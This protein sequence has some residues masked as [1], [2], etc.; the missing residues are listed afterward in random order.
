[1]H[2]GYSKNVCKN[3]VKTT[4]ACS[5]FT[6]LLHTFMRQTAE[7]ERPWIEKKNTM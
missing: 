1:M 2:L 6:L 7:P 3:E 4:K 5:V